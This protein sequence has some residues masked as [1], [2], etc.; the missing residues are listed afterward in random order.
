MDS[1]EYIL[2]ESRALSA[3]LASIH[4]AGSQEDASILVA[5]VLDV[6][7]EPSDTSELTTR[8]AMSF[9]L[10]RQVEPP[11]FK[12]LDK[13][14]DRHVFESVSKGW[15]TWASQ[16]DLDGTLK[17][18]RSLSVRLSGKSYLHLMALNPWKSAVEALLE[19][20]PAESWKQ[21]RRASELGAQF[22]TES[23]PVIQWTFAAS[24][25]FTSAVVV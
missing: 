23:N 7:K 16:G 17:E 2:A 8:A 13:P 4:G 24:F 5:S 21:F 22:G 11:N 1:V 15:I 3:A 14:H 25:F 12:P 19:R 10:G 9:I 20:N 18:L 6:Q